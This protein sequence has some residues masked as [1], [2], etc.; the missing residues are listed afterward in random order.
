MLWLVVWFC[1][2]AQFRAMFFSFH[3]VRAPLIWSKQSEDTALDWMR[4]R[5]RAK[6]YHL[7]IRFLPSVVAQ[8][9][10][11][12]DEFGPF[13]YRQTWNKRGWRCRRVA[14]K[15]R[16]KELMVFAGRWEYFWASWKKNTCGSCHL[17]VTP[18]AS[19]CLMV[20]FHFPPSPPL[21][22]YIWVWRCLW[23]ANLDAINS[24]L[25]PPF[26]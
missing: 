21:L 9:G 16:N 24:L 5:D 6:R 1:P 8:I 18:W 11:G 4:I 2:V 22:F 7:F 25:P 10:K 17:P 14:A 13:C 3:S 20:C 15:Q 12:Q 23:S 26:C 19:P